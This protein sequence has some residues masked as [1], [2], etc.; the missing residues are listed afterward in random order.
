M[1]INYSDVSDSDLIKLI[2]NNDGDALNFILDK[3]KPLVKYKARMFF[4]TGGETDDLI[5]E[6]MIGLFNAIR[7]FEK[8][9]NNTFKTFAEVCITNQIKSALRNSTRQKHNS[10]NFFV[11]LEDF[12]EILE[13]T[14][15][16]PLGVI[17]S[18]E[19]YNDLTKNIYSE[20]TKLEQIVLENYL[21]GKSRLEIAEIIGKN[22]KSVSN[23]LSRIR[24]KLENI[25]EDL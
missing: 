1:L 14:D 8:T 15:N 7:T 12:N 17:L 25:K 4:L 18:K 22:E 20:L 24:K 3:Y 10:L 11:P 21:N 19:T 13:S 16:E 2:R 6:G 23:S 5:Q 9:D